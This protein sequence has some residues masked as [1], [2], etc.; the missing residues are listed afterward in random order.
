MF[1]FFGEVIVRDSQELQFFSCNAMNY[2]LI[3]PKS[4]K[5]S[6]Q[7]PGVG[8]CVTALLPVRGGRE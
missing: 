8:C 3:D 6:V 2:A 1:G 7:S 5:G 4:V